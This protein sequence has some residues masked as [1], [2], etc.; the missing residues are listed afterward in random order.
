[1][2]QESKLQICLICLWNIQRAELWYWK[3]ACGLRCCFVIQYSPPQPTVDAPSVSLKWH[4]RL[5]TE[6]PRPAGLQLMSVSPLRTSLHNILRCLF[7]CFR[8]LLW[9]TFHWTNPTWKSKSLENT[10]LHPELA[11]S[12]L[13]VDKHHFLTLTPTFRT[14]VDWWIKKPRLSASGPR[15]EKKTTTT[16]SRIA[17]WEVSPVSVSPSP[18]EQHACHLCW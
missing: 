10:L 9:I 13:P 7:I 18:W 3:P 16:K 1:M 2:S 11:A 12:P 8:V 15:W 5:S 14:L 4:L 6:C 17:F